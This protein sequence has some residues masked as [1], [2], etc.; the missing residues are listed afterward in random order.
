[1]GSP[2]TGIVTNSW[3]RK[4]PSRTLSVELQ[5]I[6]LQS[7]LSA[8]RR[9]CGQNC[10]SVFLASEYLY[11]MRS[12]KKYYFEEGGHKLHFLKK[13]TCT[14]THA[15]VHAHTYTNRLRTCV[16]WSTARIFY[17][18][19][20]GLRKRSDFNVKTMK[21]CLSVECSLSSLFTTD[22]LDSRKPDQ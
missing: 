11:F 17:D 12:L 8:Q 10:I 4:N 22:P 7:E 6:Y 9:I 14:H 2:R 16:L 19:Q 20:I 15:R 3:L 13:N 5:A 18:R 21:F 1:M